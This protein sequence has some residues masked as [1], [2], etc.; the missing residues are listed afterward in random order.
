[1]KSKTQKY[2]VQL[3]QPRCRGGAIRGPNTSGEAYSLRRDLGLWHLIFE[4]HPAILKHEQG[5]CYVAYL[6]THPSGEPIHGL[7]LALKAA[8]AYQPTNAV[9][10][11]AEPS[12]GELVSVNGSS[13]MEEYNLQLDDARA[14]WAMRRKQ[15]DLEALVDDPSQSEPVKAEA[16]RELEA[17]YDY[18]KKNAG[19]TTS[20]AQRAVRTVRMAIKRFHRHL[21]SAVTLDGTA[22]P[23]LQAFAAHLERYLLMPSI[24]FCGCHRARTGLGLAGRFTYEPPPGV[25]WT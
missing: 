16:L 20:A 14:A 5:I 7:A 3:S 15:L 19:R 18:Q 24:R 1:M 10:Q 6:V 9:T 25:V 4:S 21:A 22:H 23:V 11:I 12:T 2:M 8:A 17:I 13:V